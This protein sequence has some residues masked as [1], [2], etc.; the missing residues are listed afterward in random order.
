[1][2]RPPRPLLPLRPNT[3]EYFPHFAGVPLNRTGLNGLGGKKLLRCSIYILAAEASLLFSD[4]DYMLR[5]SM[6]AR[7]QLPPVI[8]F[9]FGNNR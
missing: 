9:Q 5:R 7:E 2:L 3:T 6:S 1:M 4:R 8:C